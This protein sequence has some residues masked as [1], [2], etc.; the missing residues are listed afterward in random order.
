MKKVLNIM[1]GVLLLISAA[2][3]IFAMASNHPENPAEYDAAVS[4]NLWWGYLLF[5]AAIVA[6][7]ACAVWGMVKNPAGI[8]GTVLSL[9]LIV[10][11][12]GVSYFLS[13]SHDVQIVDLQNNGFFSRGETVITETSVL[14]TYVAM[15]AAF[16]TAIATEIWGA[17]K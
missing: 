17:F 11:I 9:V 12:V 10:V 14:V 1:L 8:K 4:M 7:I 3:A 5:G 15:A 2:L 13:A 16:V 6:A